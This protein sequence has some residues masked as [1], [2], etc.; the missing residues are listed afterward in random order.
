M[1]YLQPEAFNS[2]TLRAKSDQFIGLAQWEI[3]PVGDFEIIDI[4]YA[5]YTGGKLDSIPQKFR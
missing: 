2:T 3:K 4:A 1:G 5:P